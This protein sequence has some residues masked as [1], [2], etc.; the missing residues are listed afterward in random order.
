MGIRADIDCLIIAGFPGIGKTST[1]NEM[2]KVDIGARCIDMD[3]K[4]EN[5]TNGID[6]A[7]PADYV[8]R[9]MKLS[10]ENAI[11]FVTTDPVVRQ[12]MREAGLFYMIVA[13]EF[14]DNFPIPQQ[15][16]PDPLAR[17]QYMQ[18]FTQIGG[19]SKAGE[20]LAGRGYADAIA[21]LF[22]DPRP[23][24]VM[25]TLTRQGV[26]VMWQQLEMQTRDMLGSLSPEAIK[27]LP[28]AGAGPMPGPSNIKI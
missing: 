26:D 2:K 13:P 3:V 1:Y 23:K 16:R 17:A 27:D 15:F 6:V 20:T 19:N 11:I 28:L 4:Y 18:R 9:V 25:Q 12:K 5:T 14:P 7:D 24:A 21:D 8:N 10:K 22:G